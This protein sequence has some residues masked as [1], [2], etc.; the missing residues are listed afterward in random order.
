[1]TDGFAKSTECYDI[2]L[3]VTGDVS[4]SGLL[5]VEKN[6]YLKNHFIPSSQDQ[7]LS[8]EV[9]VGKKKQNN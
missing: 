2:V 8:E 9:K 7:M 4:L 3:V 5:D 6:C 1:M